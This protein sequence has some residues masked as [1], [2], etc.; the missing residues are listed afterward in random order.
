MSAND[1]QVGGDHYA[2]DDSGLKHWDLIENHGIGYLEGCASKYVSR[3]RKKNGLQDLE[4][5]LHYTEKLIELAK[6][7][8]FPRGEVST[9]ALQKFADANGLDVIER[10]CLVSLLRWRKVSDLSQ[11][12]NC[13]NLLIA[14]ANHVPATTVRSAVN[15]ETSSNGQSSGLD[16][17]KACC[18]R[19]GDA[20][21]APEDIGDRS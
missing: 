10:A 12:V 17:S 15:V 3:W 11:A 8:R 9:S 20:G 2:A 1:R 21:R 14:Q 5:G 13:F 18:D 4:K 7:W 19:H 6:D 16:L